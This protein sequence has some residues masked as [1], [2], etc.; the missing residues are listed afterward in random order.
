M[1]IY[2]K[3]LHENAQVPVKAH[4]GDFCYDCWAV[5]EE[6]VAPNVWKY[7][8]GFT[9]QPLNE[10]DYSV[11]RGICIR[12]RSGV[13][14]T[15]MI[16]SNGIG[17]DDVEE[18]TGELSAVFY[19]VMPDMP[20]YKVGDRVCQ[21]CLEKTE[22]LHFIETTTLRETSRGDGSYGSTGK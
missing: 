16:L 22:P 12:A 9:L 17:T 11:I 19:H 7:G 15:G 2:F 20:R 18:Y 13:W 10:T 5:S 1:N 3:K 6:E 14:K 21:L 4:E 8:L